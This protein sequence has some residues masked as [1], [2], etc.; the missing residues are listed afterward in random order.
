MVISVLFSPHIEFAQQPKFD[1]IAKTDDNLVLYINFEL[2]WPCPS[3]SNTIKSSFCGHHDLK[4]SQTLTL[5]RKPFANE[6][7]L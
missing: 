4:K 6:K 5:T 2:M 7:C 3:I 1:E